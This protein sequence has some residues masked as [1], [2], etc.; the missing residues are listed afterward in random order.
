MLGADDMRVPP[1]QGREYFRALK[2]RNKITRY[3]L[4]FKQN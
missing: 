2:A 4:Y 3:D 1:K